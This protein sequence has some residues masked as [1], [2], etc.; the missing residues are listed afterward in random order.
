MPR[1]L[2]S[3][4]MDRHTARALTGSRQAEP[5]RAA[6][7]IPERPTLPVARNTALLSAAQAFHS[8]MQQ[9]AAVSLLLDFIRRT[10]HERESA[11][12]A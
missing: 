7:A 12:G 6:A 5:T 2:P 9:L 8:A 4:R 11:G 3:E 1:H 10:Q